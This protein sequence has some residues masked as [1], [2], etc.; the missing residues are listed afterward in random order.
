[1]ILFIKKDVINRELQWYESSSFLCIKLSSTQLHDKAI[2]SFKIYDEQ[3]RQ[4]KYV[5][6]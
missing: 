4:S 6:E 2:N 5:N 3:G 1:M